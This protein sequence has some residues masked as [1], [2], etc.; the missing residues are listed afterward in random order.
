LN[1]F[2]VEIFHIGLYYKRIIDEK[3]RLH[4][5]KIQDLLLLESEEHERR[6]LFYHYNSQEYVHMLQESSD[7]LELRLEER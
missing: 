6:H 1:S 2:I 5:F 7:R 3:I 4:V